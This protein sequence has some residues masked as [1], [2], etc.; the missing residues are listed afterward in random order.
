MKSFAP[1]L[2]VGFSYDNLEGISDGS[3]ASDAYLELASG[4]VNDQMEIDRLRAALL[5]YCRRDTLALV[6]VHH[7][8]RRLAFPSTKEA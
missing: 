7:A 3:A 2:C 6:E 5:A 8:L 1:A 4:H